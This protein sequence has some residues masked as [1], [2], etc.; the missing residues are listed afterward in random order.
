VSGSRLALA[1]SCAALLAACTNVPDASEFAATA[2]ALPV[3]IS[4]RPVTDAR[5][6]FRQVFC[7]IA[8]QDGVV[9]GDEADC[10]HLLW[11][12]ADEPAPDAAPDASRPAGASLRWFVVTGALSDCFGPDAT[13][14]RSGVSRLSERG[15]RIDLVQVSGRSGTA[16]NARQIAD[17]LHAAGLQPSDRIALLGYSKGAV[18]I[19]QLLVDYPELAAR[20]AAVVSVSGPILGSPLAA[21]GDWAYRHLFAGAF[22]NHC[23]PG[24]GGMVGSLVPDTRKQWLAEHPPPPHVRYFSL[25]AFTTREHLP[26]GLV[27]TWRMLAATDPRNDGQVLI[28]DAIIPGSTLLGYANADHWGLALT[29]EN[30]MPGIAARSDP[31]P[32]PQDQLLATIVRYISEAVTGP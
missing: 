30:V 31:R 2:A 22:A 20:I 13:P 7:S 17:A 8:R 15:E 4:G 24:D 26:R 5:A 11:K 25:G 21:S 9:P 3:D 16:H 32:Y 12:L 23:D 19:L 27:P 18:D 10:A 1:A 6:S 28:G 14:F 29:I